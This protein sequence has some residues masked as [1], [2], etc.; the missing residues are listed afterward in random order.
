M[1]R[2]R[3]FTQLC[4]WKIVYERHTCSGQVFIN[5]L[6]QSA[7]NIF[8]AKDQHA[9]QY[10]AMFKSHLIDIS[11]DTRAAFLWGDPDPDQWSKDCPDHGA[12]KEPANPL[13][14]WIHWFLW[15]TIIQTDL[16][17]L[18]RI[19][20][21]PKECSLNQHSVVSQLGVYQLI[22]IDQK[23]TH[24]PH[25]ISKFRGPLTTN[26]TASLPFQYSPFGHCHE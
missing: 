21:T 7:I 2:T 14:S 13:W 16:G 20:I 12:S 15:C 5:T 8:I 17:S 22:C 4:T 11:T 26:Q 1:N 19:R 3:Y 10:Q 6:D 24:R 9:N 25:I 23:L 18:V